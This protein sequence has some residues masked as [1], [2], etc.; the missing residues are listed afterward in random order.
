MSRSAPRL[1]PLAA[2]IGL[3]CLSWG[4]GGSEKD[5]PSS[6]TQASGSEPS[7]TQASS[8]AADPSGGTKPLIGFANPVA[9]VPSQQGLIHGAKDAAAQLGLELQVADANL[10]GDKQVSDVESFVT[11]DAKGI[12]T[13]TLN[14]GA[15][16]AAYQKADG[17]GIPVV[18][19]NSTSD[20]IKTVIK[21]DT[22][23]TCR[24]M[25]D[26][27]R[28]I[29]SRRPKAKVFVMGGPPVESITLAVDCFQKAAKREGLDIVDKK[30][31]TENTIASAQRIMADVLTQHPDLE[32]AWV[33]NDVGGLGISAA[34]GAAD[35]TVWSGDKEGFILIG[36]DGDQPAVEAIKAGQ[37]TA[38]YDSNFPLA[39]GVAAAVLGRH[40]KDGSPLP[41]TVRVPY[42]RIELAN[43]GE[44]VDPTR[45][46]VTVNGECVSTKGVEVCLH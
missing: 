14:Q 13:W 3:L 32:A 44:Y 37:Y 19:F 4:C 46:P 6:S 27:A 38:T 11:R 17:A 2:I 31:N 45:R 42:T 24:P 8:P 12:M 28:Y 34:L 1:V 29:A 9:T 23:S 30:D 16:D 36:K 40:I 35:K 7:A 33:F 21:T 43:A 41:P 20:Y 25:D 26:A 15:A 18:G 39:G 10:S 5:S 22:D